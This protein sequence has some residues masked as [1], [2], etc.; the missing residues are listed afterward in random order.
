MSGEVEIKFRGWKWS[1]KN[2]KRH[3]KKSTG[4]IPN[5][6]QRKKKRKQN[7]F[8]FLW[9]DDTT[10]NKQMRRVVFLHN[11]YVPTMSQAIEQSTVCMCGC[12]CTLWGL[13]TGTGLN[14]Q[15]TL[16]TQAA[17]SHFWTKWTSVA[18]LDVRTTSPAVFQFHLHVDEMIWRRITSYSNTGTLPSC[19]LAVWYSNCIW[20]PVDGLYWIWALSGRRGDHIA[21]GPYLWPAE[22]SSR[23]RKVKNVFKKSSRMNI[24][25]FGSWI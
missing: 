11:C 19:G 9:S 5:K 3:Q 20:Q 2:N 10:T 8:S 23:T 18:P 22:D 1:S 15:T 21:P 7:K 6:Q 4:L 17:G 25:S 12:M 24:P 13:M 16:K 14:A